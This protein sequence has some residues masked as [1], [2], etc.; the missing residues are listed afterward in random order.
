MLLQTKPMKLLILALVISLL[1]SCSLVTSRTIN[2]P[3][4]TKPAVSKTPLKKELNNLPEIDG[5]LVYIGVNNFKDL[6]GKRK[7]SDTVA[8]FSSVVTQGGEAWLMESLMESGWFK[9]L[10]RAESESVLRERA[11]VTQS[12]NSF[13]EKPIPLD[14]LRVSTSTGE[15]LVTTTATKTVISTSTNATMFRFVDL[16][17]I[18]AEAEIGLAK[19]ELVSKAVRSAID[20]ALIDLIHKG[21]K[22][23]YWKFKK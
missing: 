8:S 10:E 12:R 13:D 4:F 21:E 20:K 18:P 6:T 2:K 3:E 1:T 15:V 22:K 16:D 9:V 11:L 19:N 5:E 14:P 17:T 7:S 23:D